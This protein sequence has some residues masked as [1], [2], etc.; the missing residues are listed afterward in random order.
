[1]KYI[2][3][4][5]KMNIVL[6]DDSIKIIGI[7]LRTS[8]E[9]GVAFQEIPPFWQKFYAENMLDKIPNKIADDIYAVY[10][11]FDH[12]GVNN[13]GMYSLIIGC[14]VNNLDAIPASLTSCII[15]ASQ[16]AIFPLEDN[17][18][19]KVGVK[20]QEIW[21]LSDG[22]KEF[23]SRRSYVAEFEHYA[24]SGGIDIHIGLKP[25]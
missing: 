9:N 19:E 3:K 24:P 23:D 6:Q 11:K 5:V 1:L 22:N 13:T 4:G 12:E 21:Q 17:S 15:P 25:S 10:T 18:P 16:Y 8:N 14:P 20:W 7:E 2:Y